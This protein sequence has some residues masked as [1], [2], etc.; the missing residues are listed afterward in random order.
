MFKKVDLDNNSIVHHLNSLLSSSNSMKF[1]FNEFLV[2][3]LLDRFFKLSLEQNLLLQFSISLPYSNSVVKFKNKVYLLLYVLVFEIL[4]SQ[5]PRLIPV[6]EKTKISLKKNIVINA[7]ITSFS[8]FAKIKKKNFF[9]FFFFL[10]LYVSKNTYINL[11]APSKFINLGN[12]FDHSKINIILN[13]GINLF[14]LFGGFDELIVSKLKITICYKPQQS[15][16]TSNRAFLYYILQSL[17]FNV[18]TKNEEKMTVSSHFLV[19][20]LLN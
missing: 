2:L 17:N 11:V 4:V 1:F 12:M 16:Y 15:I 9:N 8:I 18:M 3:D 7:T 5:K 13:S 6:Y 10:R 14:E 19:K 20:R